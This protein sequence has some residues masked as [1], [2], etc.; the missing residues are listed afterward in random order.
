MNATEVSVDLGAVMDAAGRVRELL[1][2]RP[3]VAV[4]EM[5]ERVQVPEAL[6]RAALGLLMNQGAV[7]R[8]RPVFYDRDDRD[9]YRLLRESDGRYLFGPHLRQTLWMERFETVQVA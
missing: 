3:A 9:Y 4:G 5:V 8:L 1:L 2:Q 6:V 7:E